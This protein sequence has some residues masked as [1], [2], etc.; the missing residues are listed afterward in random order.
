MP[1]QVLRRHLALTWI[2][3]EGI[4]EK[5]GATLGNA[6]TQYHVCKP[7]GKLVS[8][9]VGK[10]ERRVRPPGRKAESRDKIH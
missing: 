8:L 10:V 2:G 1:K 3:T 4:G 9:K 7:E 6:A 5:V